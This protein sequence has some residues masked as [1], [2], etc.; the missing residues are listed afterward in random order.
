ME[1]RQL[2]LSE[3]GGIGEEIIRLA[4]LPA[5]TPQVSPSCAAGDTDFHPYPAQPKRAPTHHPQ[6]RQVYLLRRKQLQRYGGN[7]LTNPG[8]CFDYL[9]CFPQ[10][11]LTRS[12]FT[13]NGCG[14]FTA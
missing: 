12:L 14:G 7:A 13:L 5:H 9:S 4:P 8:T 3:H 10:N 2:V 11:Q 1:K 6:S